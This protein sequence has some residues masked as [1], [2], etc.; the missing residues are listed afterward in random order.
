M[1]DNKGFQQNNQRPGQSQNQQ[2]NRPQQ[3]NQRPNNAPSYAPTEEKQKFMM[4][5]STPPLLATAEPA[6]QKYVSIAIIAFLLGFGAASLWFGDAPAAGKTNGLSATSTPSA[7]QEE[8]SEPTLSDT[9]TPSETLT[10]AVVVVNQT[11]GLSVKV[12]SVTLTEPAWVVV[13]ET[14]EGGFRYL[15]A[16]LFDAGTTNNGT[17]ELLRGTIAGRTYDVVARSDNGDHAFDPK[18]DLPIEGF[19]GAILSSPFVALEQ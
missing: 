15:G 11:A 9:T 7:T 19:G 2:Q 18:I 16:Q 5:E 13:T 10:P 4:K 12:A 17:I 6:G 14:V 1:N 3:N 8:G